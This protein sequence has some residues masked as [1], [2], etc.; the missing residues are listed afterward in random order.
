M[1]TI[2]F[3]RIEDFR[4]DLSPT[5]IEEAIAGNVRSIAAQAYVYDM[6]AFLHLR[7]LADIIQARRHAAP[8]EAPLGGWLLMRNLATPATRTVTPNNDTLY[9][10]SYLLLDR[11]GPV[12]L[13]VPPIPDRYYSVAMLDADLD[14][15]AIVS[16]RTFGNS[17]G[18]YLIT[19][20]GWTGAVPDGIDA[21]F[22]APTPAIALF[23]R[24][25]VRNEGDVAN[26]RALQDAISL[27]PLNAAGTAGSAFPHI[28][29]SSF[30][31]PGLHDLRDP[32]RYFELTNFYTGLNPRPATDIG[33]TALFQSA[34]VGPA[35]TLPDNPRLREAIAR[36]ALD[37]QEAINARISAGPFRRGWRIPDPGA[38]RPG[39]DYLA[40]AATQTIMFGIFP[41]EEAIYFLGQRDSNGE[42]LNGQRRYTFTF[43]PG[44]L[45]PLGEYGF[46]S[47]TMYDAAQFLVGN[48]LNRYSLRPDSPNLTHRADGSLTIYLQADPPAGVP[49]GNWLPAPEGDFSV[50]L[51]TYL[52]RTPIRDGSWF[53]PGIRLA[54]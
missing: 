38:G 27:A 45:P 20:P 41:P 4:A 1:N 7:Q 49:E 39:T 34:G 14:T 51:R 35:S 46:W 2:T 36:G 50:V 18:T 6:P 30:D 19:P 10:A 29:L 12:V 40:R 15:F 16:P 23:Q 33:L 47:L 26:V 9:G 25:F 8:T 17:G 22:A 52:P 43:A 37:G 13:T 48:P 5:E 44:G 31:L 3:P 21:M 11:Q 53:P 54:G 24:I 28:D 42:Q 32:L